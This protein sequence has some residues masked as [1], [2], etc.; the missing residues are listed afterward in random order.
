MQ[1]W[2]S[3]EKL[4]DRYSR[5][6]LTTQLPRKVMELIDAVAAMNQEKRAASG[7]EPPYLCTGL[8]VFLTREPCAM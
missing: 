7:E 6:E 8:D 5:D 1:V 2:S 3:T 4:C